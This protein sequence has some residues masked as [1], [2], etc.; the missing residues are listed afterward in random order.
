MTNQ[1]QPM[2]FYD[3]TAFIHAVGTYLYTYMRLHRE[4][5]HLNCLDAFYSSPIVDL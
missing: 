2:I 1:S 5:S 4:H 3:L